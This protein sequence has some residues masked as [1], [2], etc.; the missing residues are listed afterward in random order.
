MKI[1]LQEAFVESISTR[2]DRSLK[3]VLSTQQLPPEEMG[4]LFESFAKFQ[5]EDVEAMTE[6]TI[7]EAYPKEQR[8]PHQRLRAILYAYW[9]RAMKQRYPLFDT[10][11][12]EFYESLIEEK[13]AQLDNLKEVIHEKE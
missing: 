7:A 12:D 1:D 4:K 13:K 9:M 2:P 6:F 11:Y 5:N 3:I 10:Y 8:S